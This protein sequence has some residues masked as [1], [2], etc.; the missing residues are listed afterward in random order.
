MQRSLMQLTRGLW[1]LLAVLLLTGCRE[2]PDQAALD[3]VIQSRLTQ[4]F[5]PQTFAIERLRR[6]GS[7]PL[8][9]DAQGRARQIVYFN[10]VLGLERDLD[11]SSWD[12]L[13]IAAFASL[14]GATP[15]GV[16]GL[17]QAGNRRGDRVYVHGS[18]SFVRDAAAAEGWVPVAVTL[19]GVGTPSAPLSPASSAASQQLFARLKQLYARQSADPK[20]QYRIINEELD[21]AYVTITQ[22]LDR[23]EHALILAGGPA[24][25]EYQGV[26]QL[27][28]QTLTARGRTA[29]AL[30]T[31][32]S[33]E[34]LALLRDGRADL[35]LVQNDLAAAAL[36]GGDGLAPA[37]PQPTLRVLASLFPE[38]LHLIVAADSA[39][40]TPHDLAGRRLEIGQPNSG[41]R[42][43]ALLLLAAAG[44]DVKG[45]AAVREGGLEQGLADLAAGR[46]D[47]VIATI[48]APAARIQAAA[49]LGLIRLLPIAPDLQHALAGQAAGLVPI[50]LPPDTYPGQVE[51]VPTLAAT[52]LLV[53]AERL[54]RADVDLVLGALFGGIDF[55]AAGSAA[56]SQINRRS[57][58]VGLTLPLHPAAEV[59]FAGAAS[60]VH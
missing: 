19:P 25:G 54:P 33:A 1:L 37:G 48:S 43:N 26:A 44:V 47:A 34:N 41:S 9:A 28:A 18:A 10:A 38:P 24:G 16:S 56:G 55:V 27:L 36:P 17:D 42:A 8:A 2:A 29:D 35:A 21:Q 7:G 14:L 46:V 5:G 50:Q 57:A 15:L 31:A 58:A 22:R 49:A 6:L 40:R 39:L 60:P 53:A 45:L 12:T 4:A 51:A 23:L 32:G 3:A 20:R 13:N 11:F 30:T 52:A 59:F